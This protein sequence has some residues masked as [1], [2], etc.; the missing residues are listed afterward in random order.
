MLAGASLYLYGERAS[1]WLLGTHLMIPSDWSIIAGAS[2]VLVIAM[3]DDAAKQLLN[4]WVFRYLGRIS[5]SLYLLHPI[6]LLAA[7]HAFNGRLPL[8]AILA[9]GFAITFPVADLAQRMI[10]QP[11]ARLGRR[12]ADYVSRERMA[13]PR[14]AYDCGAN[15][16]SATVRAMRYDSG[17]DE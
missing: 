16:R 14:E 17:K 10:E 4:R 15:R 12:A 6:V 5:Y 3:S 13:P 8:W 11:A 2:L 9:G 7:L 1:D